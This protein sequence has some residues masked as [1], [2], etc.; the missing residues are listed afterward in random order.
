[1][2]AIDVVWNR[3]GRRS[4][5]Q[6]APAA[7][8]PGGSV[9]PTTTSP[10]ALRQRTAAAP[11]FMQGRQGLD[12]AQFVTRG[13]LAARAHR[14]L[15][16]GATGTARLGQLQPSLIN[17]YGGDVSAW[18]QIGQPW[19][20]ARSLARPIDTLPNQTSVGWLLGNRGR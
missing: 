17:A 8:R 9:Q 14:L 16:L 15:G 18:Q 4:T 6:R 1:M 13:P 7:H 5:T 2:P 19:I 20:A 11:L 10:L 3:E 12:P